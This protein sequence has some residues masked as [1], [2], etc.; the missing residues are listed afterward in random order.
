M[1]YL[2]EGVIAK[3]RCVLEPNIKLNFQKIGSIGVHL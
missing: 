2:T 1:K 3:N